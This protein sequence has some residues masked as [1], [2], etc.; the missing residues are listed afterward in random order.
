MPS[1]PLR[2]SS[3]V[4]SVAPPLNF[5]LPP[6]IAHAAVRLAAVVVSAAALLLAFAG[7]ARAQLT[8][9]GVAWGTPAA[10]ARARFAEQGYR[11][12]GADQDGDLVF[13]GPARSELVVTLDSAGVAGVELTQT[14][15]AAQARARY[16]ALADSLRRAL[17]APTSR[18]ETSAAW[19]RGGA[20]LSAW[21]GSTGDAAREG[22][23]AGITARGPGFDAEI[24]RRS[25]AERA[26]NDRLESGEQPRDTLM[27]GDWMRTYSDTR[28]LASFDS[29][30]SVRVG[31]GVYRTRF[32]ESWMFTRRLENGTKYTGAVRTVEID[33][34]A[35]R[36]RLLRTVPFYGRTSSPPEDVSPAEQRWTTPA[37]GS[38]EAREIR[39]GCELLGATARTR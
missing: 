8:V 17:G 13:W 4:P 16:T 20:T 7:M 33:C 39:R 15:T 28:V 21:H 12:R 10:Q 38:A 37:A 27:V 14:G 5:T 11:F 29:S 18:D 3:D 26:V 6:M 1:R 19:E 30:G 34:G 31:P 9:G 35:L 2:A 22:P 32:R 23:T 36:E 24:E 25:G